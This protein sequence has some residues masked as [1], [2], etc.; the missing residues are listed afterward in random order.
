MPAT[1]IRDLVIKDD[2]L[3]IGTHGRSFWILDGIT[4]LRQ[5][6]DSLARADAV[7]YRP[8]TGIRVRWNQNVDTP[9]PPEEP[10]GENPPDGAIIDYYVRS[11]ASG[12]VTLQVTDTAGHMIRQF[13]STDAEEPLVE[14]RNI[15]DF[16][17]RPQQRLSTTAGLH[18]FV[19]DLHYPPPAGLRFD[20]NI[21]ALYRNTPRS[22]LGP[23][24]QPGRYRVILNV[25]G[26]TYT[27]PLTVRMDPRVTTPAAGLQQ[28]FTLSMN[29]TRALERDTV[30][31][32]QVRAF[33]AALADR[34]GR[35]SGPLSDSIGAAEK[36]AAAFEGSDGGYVWD[37]HYE[38][39]HHPTSRLPSPVSTHNWRRCTAI[40]RWRTPLP[41]PRLSP[42]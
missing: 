36:A 25:N 27:Q 39:R 26:K 13:S 4:P 33:T 22:P 37:L 8:Q 30:A 32:Q 2:D 12:P 31:L 9:L 16:W 40:F 42:R 41:R 18:R 21:A 35:A 28:Q 11:A 20:Y 17:I 5:L 1:S 29:V 10:A 14:G 23:W 3:V 34:R 6:A 15:G 24:A 19:W 38:I 7:L